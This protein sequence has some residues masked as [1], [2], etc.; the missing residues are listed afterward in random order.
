VTQKNQINQ[1]GYCVRCKKKQVI[2]DAENVVMKNGRKAI[3]GK[4]PE[5]GTGMY[6]IMPTKVETKT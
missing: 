2:Q 5:C 4:C 3:R 6:R 1:E